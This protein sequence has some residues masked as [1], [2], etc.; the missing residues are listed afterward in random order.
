VRW[1]QRR[2]RQRDAGTQPSRPSARLIGIAVVAA[3][4]IGVGALA[5]AGAL[6]AGNHPSAQHPALSPVR[7]S[8]GVHN[9]TLSPSPPVGGGLTPAQIRAAYDL[10]PLYRQGI[11]GAKQTI[12]LVDSFGS[13]TIASDLAHFDHYFGLPAP[14]SFRVIQPAGKVPA[15]H[16]SNSNRSGWAAETTLDVEWAHV[17]AP[18]A[19]IVLVETPTSENE[20]TTGFPQIVTAE[21]YALRHKLGQVISQSF[22][23]TE[24]TF[25]HKSDFA[26]IRNLRGAY[27]LAYRDHVTVV[28]A[29]GDEG[30]T[31]YK[32]NMVD[33]YTT[34][35]VSWPATDPLVTAVGGTQLNLRPNGGRK[36]PDVAWNGSGGGRSI[37]FGRPSYQN[38]VRGVTGPHRGVPDIS[39]DASCNSS[40]AIY[41]SFYSGQRGQ[42]ST[43]CGTSLAT[44]L[45]A[46]IVALAY[47][48]AHQ[49]GGHALGLINPAL[50][51]IE[52]LHEPGMVD[53]TKGNNSQTVTNG[54][55]S[56]R[57]KGFSAGPGYDLVTGAGTIDA[58]YFVPE[59]A[60]L[61]G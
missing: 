35:A 52:A 44:P 1:I 10:G 16:A 14:P 7:I 61:A 43:I 58:R 17:M 33:E 50:Y 4:A 18:G 59:L 25:S 56:Y 15:Y 11:D 6:A 8:P 57:V 21:K 54:G 60:K 41:G 12:V 2:T 9:G 38:S 3:A 24:Q 13:P 19:R 27:Q 53:I 46:G 51:K 26:A 42:W 29:T 55:K 22:A 47:Q 40:V 37:V 45:F 20:G 48:Y 39:M 30:V 49:H 23:A 31:S 28:G 32:Y 36:S 34:P 5:A